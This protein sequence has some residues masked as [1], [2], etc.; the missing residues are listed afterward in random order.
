MSFIDFI[1]ACEKA[2]GGALLRDYL[3]T[4]SQRD[5]ETFFSSKGFK[6]EDMNKLWEAKEK[7]KYFC[8]DYEYINGPGKS[9]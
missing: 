5:M 1:L 7:G 6:I 4:K 9:Y 2:E 8:I 3:A